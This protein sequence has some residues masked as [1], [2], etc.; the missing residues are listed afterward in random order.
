MTVGRVWIPSRKCID[1]FTTVGP[2]GAS[3]QPFEEKTIALSGNALLGKRLCRL[4]L[5]TGERDRQAVFG[6]AVE[7]LR[8]GGVEPCQ[9]AAIFVIKRQLL[10]GDVPR[11]HAVDGGRAAQ[12]AGTKALA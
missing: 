4:H 9:R 5:L 2:A 7:L 12:R 10:A 6:L 11:F 1:Y 8:S 3:H